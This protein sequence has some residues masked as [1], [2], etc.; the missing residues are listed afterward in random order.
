MKISLEQLE[1]VA[2]NGPRV[3]PTENEVDTAVIK[4]TDADLI[5]AV[6]RRVAETPDRDDMVAELKARIEAGTY[7]V[8]GDDIVDAMIRRGKADRI[9]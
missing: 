3:T 8:S 4:L 5:A 9:R 6:T 7:N 1:K 2:A